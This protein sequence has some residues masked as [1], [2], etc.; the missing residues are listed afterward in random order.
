[1][2]PERLVI[3]GGA[4]TPFLRA[5]TGFRKAPAADLARFAF[6]E[7]LA[8]CECDPGE[9]DEVILGCSGQPHDAQNLARVAALRAGVPDRVP[10]V[11]V[12]RNCASGMEALTQALLRVR[13]REGGLFLVGGVESMSC[14]PLVYSQR[15]TDWFAGLARAKTPG[16]RL[17][18]LTRLRPAF[19]KPRVALIEALTDPVS[20]MIMGATAERLARDF[21][22]GR[23]AQDE[24]A[25][26]SHRKAAA[27]QRAGRFTA[28][29]AAAVGIDAEG[30]AV[31]ADNGIRAEL[32][33]AQLGKLPPFF[34]RRWG[35]V[36][37]GNSCQ[38]TD[39]AVA[40]V[41][42][43]ARRVDALGLHP[44]GY[45]DEFAYAGLDPAR[46]GLGPVHATAALLQRIGG[47][48]GRFDLIEMNEAF[49]AQMLACLQAFASDDFA[50]AHL[51]RQ[52]ALGPLDPQRLNVNGGA[53]A[54]G[55]PPGATGLRLVLTVLHELRRRGGRTAL[56]TL[57]VGG[58]QG[59]A[60]A[61]EAA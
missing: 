36:T 35:S 12:H 10:A 15:A 44:L 43:S 30:G 47:N 56:A 33:P 58:G 5:G 2:T 55:H 16:A 32:T 52:Q 1:M 60:L 49:A 11:T 3:V 6:V 40:L 46:M 38:V 61:L 31:E 34:D 13:A 41:V 39:G 51:R 8:R 19:F 28:E 45:L 29:I 17:K 27:A 23:A 24:F 57:C 21:S 42:G 4:R 59:A 54:L 14:A 37:V 25:L 9:L 20:G 26:E 53:I 18:L 50:R 22:I 7:A 48:L